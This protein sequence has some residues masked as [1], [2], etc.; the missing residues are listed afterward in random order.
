MMEAKNPYAPPKAV[1]ADASSATE[2]A[3]PA[4]VTRAVQLL[5]AAVA[6][7]FVSG[8]LNAYLTETPGVSRALYLGSLVIG[9][10]VGFL[11]V[12]WIL[13]S[14]GKGKN[15]ARIVQLVL[16]VFGILGVLMVFRMPQEV[17]A[18]IWLLYAVQMGLNLWGMILLFSAPA[19]AWFREMKG[20]VRSQ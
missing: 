15:W 8:I 16:F 9:W 14:I 10:S 20:W 1:V 18:I 5:W 13:S 6:V 11:I 17:S 7:S 2:P 19:N 3:R 4:A 12:W